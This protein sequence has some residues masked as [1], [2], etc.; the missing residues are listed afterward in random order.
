MALKRNPQGA[1]ERMNLLPTRH[2]SGSSV[3]FCSIFNGE[4]IL[5][6]QGGDRD[7]EAVATAAQKSAPPFHSRYTHTAGDRTFAFFMD[8]DGN[9]YFAVTDSSTGASALR[10]LDFMRENFHRASKSEVH[11]ELV[12]VVRRLISSL[13]TISRPSPDGMAP[14]A[15]TAEAPLL[16]RN[17]S[18][19]KTREGCEEARI[20]VSPENPRSTAVQKSLSAR[21][22]AQQN[23]RRLWWRLLKIVVV[24]DVLLCVVLFGIWLLVC[25]GFH[26][27]T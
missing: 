16:V 4:R 13:E 19:K 8:D 5:Y 7:L 26:C 22:R 15:A 18:S 20:D 6:S 1:S 12:P 23:G 21:I 25:R 9:T 10:F 27:I 2:P 14:V 11:D 3:L 24:V 17:F